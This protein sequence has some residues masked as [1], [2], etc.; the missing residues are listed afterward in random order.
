MNPSLPYAFEH[1]A[2]T[3][4]NGVLVPSRLRYR[5]LAAF[6]SRSISGPHCSQIQ[7]RSARDRLRFPCPSTEITP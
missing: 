7:V 1:S 6:R 5:Y 3:E 4:G 2:L